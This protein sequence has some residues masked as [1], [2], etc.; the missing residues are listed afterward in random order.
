MKQTTA[1]H[2]VS[3]LI[4]SGAISPLL[5]TPLW[6]EQGKLSFYLYDELL[7]RLRQTYVVLQ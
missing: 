4:M 2:L 6:R 1:L 3:A 7:K 5:Y